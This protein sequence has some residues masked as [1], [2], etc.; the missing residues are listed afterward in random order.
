VARYLRLSRSMWTSPVNRDVITLLDIRANERVLDVGAG[1]GPGVVLAARAGA[2]VVAVDPTPFMR[3]V[4]RVRRLGQRSRKRIEVLD[5]AAEHLPVRDASVDAVWAVNAM[6]HWADLDAA[7]AEIGR[8]LR[9][10]GRLM[11]V[12][13]D[14][15][16][17]AHEDHERFRARRRKHDLEFADV[18]PTVV[19]AKL[20]A[21]GFAVEEAGKTVV[22][23]RPA[24]LV[25]AMKA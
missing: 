2:H 11:V 14:F 1:M 22:A 18:D 6:H 8:V 17:P 23:G 9:Q 5:G 24:K 20:A 3:L 7:I 4:L 15:D 21:V 16:D 25:R 13:E 12:D 10:G 19:G